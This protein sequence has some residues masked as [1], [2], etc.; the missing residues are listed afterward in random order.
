LTSPNVFRLLWYVS[1][2]WHLNKIY[3]YY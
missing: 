1:G 2:L 3:T